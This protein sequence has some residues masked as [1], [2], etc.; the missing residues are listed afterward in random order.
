MIK[1][2][3]VIP[4]LLVLSLQAIPLAAQS[5]LAEQP[6]SAQQPATPGVDKNN[7]AS[8]APTPERSA[9]GKVPPE[10]S[11]ESPIDYRTNQKADINKALPMPVNM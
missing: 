7:A 4:L 3:L 11:K 1:R 6:Q 5:G 8:P 10:K 9:K 2:P